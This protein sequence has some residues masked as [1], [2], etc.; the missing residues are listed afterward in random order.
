MHRG[1]EGVNMIRS[2]RFRDDVR[3]TRHDDYCICSRTTT[4]V[5]VVI[6]I[7]LR[8]II[9][10]RA[11]VQLIPE[12]IDEIRSFLELGFVVEEVL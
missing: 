10:Q 11:W 6:S 12:D 3:F 4:H 7:R 1:V 9:E 8:E 2:I 5:Q